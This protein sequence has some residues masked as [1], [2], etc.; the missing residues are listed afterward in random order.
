MSRIILA[1]GEQAAFLRRVR[2]VLGGWEKVAHFAGV[3]PRTA[4]DWGR[5]KWRVSSEAALLLERASGVAFPRP[6]GELPEFWS[7]AKAGTAGCLKRNSL[8]GNPGTLEGRRRGGLVSQ[9][10]RWEHPEKYAGTGVMLRKAIRLPPDDVALAEFVGIVLGDGSVSDRQVRISLNK[11]TDRAFVSHVVA[12]A[13]S[14]FEIRVPVREPPGENFVYVELTGTNVVEFL[15][16]KGVCR[17]NKIA[18]Q[19]D[20]PRWVRQQGDLARACVRGLVDTDGCIYAHEHEVRGRRYRN[21]GLVFTSHSRP[22]LRSVHEVLCESGLPA[23]CDGRSHVS[24]YRW[25]GIKRYL[26]AIG[27]R[28]PKHVEKYLEW[29]RRGDRAAEGAALEMPCTG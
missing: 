8:H 14:L 9:Y 18:H 21:I 15:V 13:Q 12:L 2:E 7:T 10:R 11:W 16:S 3:H 27:S 1:V 25:A 5:E 19:M 29:A 22:L 4:R 6:A 20:L 26:E 17:G 28:N 23:R 24:I